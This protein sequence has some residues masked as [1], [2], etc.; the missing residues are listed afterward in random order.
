LVRL[1]LDRFQEMGITGVTVACHYPLFDPAFPRRDEYV[2]FFREMAQEVHARGMLLDVESHITF[3]GTPFSPIQWDWSGYTVE[4]LAAARRAMVQEILNEVKPDYLNLGTES[5]T[6]ATLTG[7]EE[8]KDP[9]AY[10]AY[11][12]LVADGLEKGSA[13]L[14]AGMGA[15]NSLGQAT[16][17]AREPWLDFLALHVYDLNPGSLQNAVLVGDVARAHGKSLVLDECW[18]YKQELG[19]QGGVAMGPEVFKRDAYSFWAPLDQQ[20]LRCMAKLGQVDGMAYVSPFWSTFFF[21]TLPY[22]E[23]LDA[24]PYQ[25]V[26][27]LANQME[28]DALLAGTRVPTGDFYADLIGQYPGPLAVAFSFSPEVPTDAAPV[29][30]TASASGGTPP[31]EFAWDLCGAAASGESVTQTLAPGSCAATLTVTDA[32]GM[33]AAATATVAV[34]YSIAISGAAWASNPP[35]L[36][37]SGSGFEQGCEVR[38]GGVPVPKTVFKGEGKLVARGDVIKTMAPKGVQVLVSVAAADGRVS[39]PFSFTR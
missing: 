12:R 37:V 36:K 27:A 2:A 1:C 3:T 25:T 38:I 7:L 19:Q 22:S 26:A 39:A 20:F 13:R 34:G 16:A 17:F 5:D 4:S 21:A 9:L 23:W 18:L 31:Y 35:R 8:L 15:W 28:Y 29:T 24:Q 32:A 14:G 33:R 6:E 30:F 11:T 10:V